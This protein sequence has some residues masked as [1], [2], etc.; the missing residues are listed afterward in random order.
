MSDYRIA[1]NK[2]RTP[3]L[4][5]VKTESPTVK[6]FAFR[7]E[8]CA[9]ARPGQ[10]LML[11]VPGIDEIPLS[12]L[13][14]DREDKVFVTVKDVGKATRALHALEK[15]ETIGVRGPFGNSFTMTKGK[16]LLVGGGTG[17]APLLF[18]TRRLVHQGIKPVFVMGAK[19][20]DELLFMHEIERICGKR[21]VVATTEDGSCGITGLCT[22]PLEK[23]IESEKPSMVYSCGP[24]RMILKVLE[25]AH[26]HKLSMEAS[27][28]RLMRCAVGICGSCM[29]GNYRVCRDGP[30]FTGNQ[31]QKT[32]QELGKSKLDLDG[33]RVRV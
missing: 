32:R 14:A 15:G 12:I 22:E 9:K 17:M 2:L 27:L 30:V 11:W 8:Y 25:L 5:S 6:T 24:E 26:R 16:T 3:L 33:R 29:I 4:E 28:E 7:D 19:T 10:F 23:L 31:L 13:G 18:L 21:N 1:A 20:G